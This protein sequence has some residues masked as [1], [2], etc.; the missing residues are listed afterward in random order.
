MDY[1]CSLSASFER[2][3]DSRR[4]FIMTWSVTTRKE[5][6]L[7]CHKFSTPRILPRT[8]VTRNFEPMPWLL[9]NSYFGEEAIPYFEHAILK[10]AYYGALTPW[11]QD[12]AHGSDSGW[13]QVSFWMPLQEATLENG[14]MHYIP[15]SH[16]AGI[17]DHTS[18]GNDST[19][20]ALE[21]RGDFDPADAVACPLPTGGCAIHHGRT[22]HYATLVQNSDLRS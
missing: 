16:R 9:Q 10:P 20:P 12:E 1:I 6:L 3:L 13:E 17:L 2:G 21:C 18:P 22:L 4:A 19:I 8:F 11:R 15:R 7:R 14:C 5:N